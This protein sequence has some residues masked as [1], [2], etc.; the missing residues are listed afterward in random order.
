MKLKVD[1]V[2]EG[3]YGYDSL[4]AVVDKESI[5]IAFD[6]KEKTTE[7]EMER[8]LEWICPQPTSLNM[9]IRRQQTAS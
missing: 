7:R 4:L 8:K 2:I 6:K 1:S 5:S 3:K 9:Q